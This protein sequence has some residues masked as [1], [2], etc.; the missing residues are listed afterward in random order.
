VEYTHDYTWL[1]LNRQAKTALLTQDH[2]VDDVSQSA[3]MP[4]ELFCSLA[5]Q[6]IRF[7]EEHPAPTPRRSP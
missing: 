6:W 2:P 5:G 3:T 1:E 4:L 7:V